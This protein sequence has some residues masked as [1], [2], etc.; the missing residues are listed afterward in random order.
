M[1]RFMAKNVLEWYQLWQIGF[2]REVKDIIST[3]LVEHK[4]KLLS[5]QSYCSA[6][7]ETSTKWTDLWSSELQE[8]IF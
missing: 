8:N 6:K 2:G 1:S 7:D 5:D 4:W 3:D